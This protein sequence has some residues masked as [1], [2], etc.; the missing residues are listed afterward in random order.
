MKLHTATLFFLISMRCVLAQS[1]GAPATQDSL[2]YS[3]S[4]NT[5]LDEHLGAQLRTQ[6]NLVSVPTL[7][8]TKGGE[9]VF[10]LKSQD[11][12]VLD[13]GIPRNV[14]LDDDSSQRP[15]AL[16]IVVQTGGVATQQLPNLR[17]FGTMIEAMVANIPHEV[18][19]VAFDSRPHLLQKFTSNLTQIGTGVQTVRAG[20]RGAGILD[21]LAFALNLVQKEPPEFRRA[22]LL[23]SEA[24]DHGSTI[25][26]NE[27]LHDVSETNTA[28]YSLT[29][30]TAK[31]ETGA[32]LANKTPP[33]C[34]AGPTQRPPGGQQRCISFTPLIAL[35]ARVGIA[36]MS[37]NTPATIARLSGGEYMQFDDEKTLESALSDLANQLPNRYMLSFTPSS[38]TPGL[39]SIQVTLKNYPQLRVS[40]RTSY[41]IADQ[42]NTKAHP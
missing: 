14:I 32:A 11:F 28:I 12:T 18:A 10:S 38:P 15:L 1:V 36:G 42:T 6:S 31:A 16:V 37:R 4:N 3:S 9:L 24:V 5:A 26:L 21:G 20:D 2:P 39:H 35:G 17:H 13:N 27:A 8:T 34:P 40:A 19:L 22:I 33:P 7:V 23:I 41:W 30:S 25:R 29:F